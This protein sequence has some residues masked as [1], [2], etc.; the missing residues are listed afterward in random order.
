VVKIVDLTGE[1]VPYITGIPSVKAWVLGVVA[2]NYVLKQEYMTQDERGKWVHVEKEYY[3]SKRFIDGYWL[4]YTGS[5]P[6]NDDD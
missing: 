4:D 6:G 1:Q 2:E 5:M 3:R